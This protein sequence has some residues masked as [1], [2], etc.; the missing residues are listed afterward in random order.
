MAFKPGISGNPKGRPKKST[1]AP[2]EVQDFIK[3]YQHDIKKAG[4]LVLKYATEHEEP[5]ALKLCLEYFYPKPGT[6]SVM[7]KEETTE[8]NL[9]INQTLSLEDQRTFLQL[10][11][12]SKRGLPAFGT[13]ETPA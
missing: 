11:M 3:E 7:T 9:N 5:W 13:S 4:A 12:K 1:T 6:Y 2:Q 8:V 10:W